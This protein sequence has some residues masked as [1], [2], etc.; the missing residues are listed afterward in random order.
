MFGGEHAAPGVAEEVVLSDPQFLEQVVEF[1]EEEL[2]GPEIGVAILFWE[3]GCIAAAE[4]IV[5]ND[6]DGVVGGQG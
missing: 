2:D 4:L 1:G 6:G 3:V 5:E